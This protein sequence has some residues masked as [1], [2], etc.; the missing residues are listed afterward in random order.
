MVTSVSTRRHGNV[1]V[2]CLHG[3]AQTLYGTITTDNICATDQVPTIRRSQSLYA[4]RLVGLKERW[5]VRRGWGER[6]RDRQTDRQTDR[7]KDKDARTDRRRP[8]ERQRQKH[9]ERQRQTARP[10]MYMSAEEK[11]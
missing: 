2:S 8:T 9:R 6:E 1:T 3:I 10:K 4:E 7:D 11:F 5:C